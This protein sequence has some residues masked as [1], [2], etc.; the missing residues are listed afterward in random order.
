MNGPA[1]LTQPPGKTRPADSRPVVCGRDWRPVS[2][3]PTPSSPAPRSGAGAQRLGLGGG[4]AHRRMQAQREV[5]GAQLGITRVIAEVRPRT[6]R[7]WGSTCSAAA[8]SRHGGDGLND[9]RPW[10]CRCGLPRSATE[11]MWRSAPATSPLLSGDLRAIRHRHR[12]QPRGDGNIART[13][14]AFVY[15]TAGIPLG[16]K[17]GGRRAFPH[18][19]AAEPDD[20]RAPPCLSALSRW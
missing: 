19:L 17:G 3:S 14:L 4:D 6:S 5:I 13:L 16:G 8:R 7:R 9:L 15:N 20:R 2:A 12:A 18:R 1:P 10:R 11:P